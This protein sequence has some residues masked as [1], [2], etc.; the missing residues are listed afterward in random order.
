MFLEMTWW[1]ILVLFFFCWSVINVIVIVSW[2]VLDFISKVI[3]KI[4]SL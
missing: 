3:K 1:E 2:G 4:Y